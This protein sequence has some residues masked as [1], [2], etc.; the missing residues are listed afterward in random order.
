MENDTERNSCGLE[1]CYSAHR[2]TIPLLERGADECGWYHR[3]EDH[4]RDA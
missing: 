1:G 2:W 4:E 3:V